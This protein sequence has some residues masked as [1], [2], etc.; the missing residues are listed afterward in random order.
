MWCVL[1]VVCWCANH[2]TVPCNAYP[3]TAPRHRGTPVSVAAGDVLVTPFPFGGEVYPVRKSLFVETYIRQAT[4]DDDDPENAR[5][6]QEV[7][8]VHAQLPTIGTKLHFDLAGDHVLA[9]VMTIEFVGEHDGIAGYWRAGEVNSPIHSS[10]TES[11]L[12]ASAQLRFLTHDTHDEHVSLRIPIGQA[13]TVHGTMDMEHTQGV[14]FTLSPPEPYSMTSVLAMIRFTNWDAPQQWTEIYPIAVD[15][16]EIATHGTL[17]I[18]G[19]AVAFK[20]VD[21]ESDAASDDGD[22]RA[23]DALSPEGLDGTLVPGALVHFSLNETQVIAEIVDINFGE[24]AIEPAGAQMMPEAGARLDFMV[25]GLSVEALIVDIMVEIEENADPRVEHASA[26]LRFLNWN[27]PPETALLRVVAAGEGTNDGVPTMTLSTDEFEDVPF[28][29][30]RSDSE[31]SAAMKGPGRGTVT[32]PIAQADLV[33]RF[34]NWD[35][36]PQPAT[37]T[38]AT[39]DESMVCGVLSIEGIENAFHVLKGERGDDDAVVPPPTRLESVC[40]SDE[41]DDGD[42][43]EVPLHAAHHPSRGSDGAEPRS[44]SEETKNPMAALASDV[45]DEGDAPVLGPVQRRLRNMK[46]KLSQQERDNNAQLGLRG[47][48]EKSHSQKLL[49]QIRM[50]HRGARS[51]SS[52]FGEYFESAD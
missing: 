24:V 27:L 51:D 15:D 23:R 48:V 32:S 44:P 10:S 39:N 52:K 33:L 9:V 2:T 41:D 18:E 31:V 13:A 49:G 5:A 11:T 16:D 25:A 22:D 6:L 37:I 47:G 3:H 40:E 50:Y 7:N 19:M 4:G 34:V 38:V 12:H 29:V 43:D 8:R 30:R 36:N 21:T 28:S 26:K 1:R 14:D 42:D 45:S 17:V 46:E 35:A 20:V